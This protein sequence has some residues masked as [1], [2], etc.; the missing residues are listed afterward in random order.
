MFAVASIAHVNGIQLAMH[1]VLIETAIGHAAGYAAIDFVF[2]ISPSFCL[3]MC[4]F[5]KNIKRGLTKYGSS[6][7]IKKRRKNHESD[8]ESLR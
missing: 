2:H 3:I 5:A 1:T 6:V 7:T 8:F 4:G